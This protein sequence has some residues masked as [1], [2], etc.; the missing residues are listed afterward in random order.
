MPKDDD[1]RIGVFI[2]ECGTNIAGSVDTDALVR[3]LEGTAI[4]VIKS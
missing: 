2:C 1:L 3:A 4:V